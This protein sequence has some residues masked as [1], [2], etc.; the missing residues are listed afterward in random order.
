[1]IRKRAV[2]LSVHNLEF[3]HREPLEECWHHET[4]HAVRRI[5]NNTHWL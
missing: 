4:A 5:G 1:M 3:D 2:E